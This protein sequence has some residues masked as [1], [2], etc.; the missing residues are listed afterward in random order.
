[1]LAGFNVGRSNIAEFTIYVTN[2]GEQLETFGRLFKA[3]VGDHR[4]AATLI[5]VTSLAS[6]GRLLR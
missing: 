4:S 6:F 3:Y 2:P 5:G 1:M